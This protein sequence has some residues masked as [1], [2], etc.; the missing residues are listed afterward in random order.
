M[1]KLRLPLDKPAQISCSNY[2]SNLEDDLEGEKK[3]IVANSSIKRSNIQSNYLT[4]PPTNTINHKMCLIKVKIGFAFH[5]MKEHSTHNLAHFNI[6]TLTVCIV[7]CIEK[8]FN[9]TRT[10]K[11]I[12]YHGSTMYIHKVHVTSD[13]YKCY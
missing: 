12:S 7:I 3:K 13:L 4:T 2:Y 1:L 8:K 9:Y 6:R 11:V 5:L 10:G